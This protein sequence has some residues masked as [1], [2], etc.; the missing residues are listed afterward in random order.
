[1]RLAVLA[2]TS[3]LLIPAAT[4][5][6]ANFNS[7]SPIAMS[8]VIQGPATPYP[9]AISVAGVSEIADVDVTLHQFSHAS[10]KAVDVLLVSPEGRSV[11]LMSDS[12]GGG[13]GSPG[14]AAVS[15][16]EL[17]FDDQAPTTIPIGAALTSGSYQPFDND[18]AGCGVPQ[19]ND[20]YPE[21]ADDPPNGTTLADFN[22]TNPQGDWLLFVNDSQDGAP[23]SIAGWTLNVKTSSNFS[24]GKLKKNKHKGTAKLSVDVPGP[25]TVAVS[26]KG[27]KAARP[28]SG[29]RITAAKAVTEAGTV[30]L[31]IKAKGKKKRKLKSTG[32]VKLKVNVTYTP[33][34]GAP[35]T[36]PKKIKLVDNG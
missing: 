26:G 30:T 16:L 13:S 27:V 4:A 36:E 2:A 33:A 14:C 31:P 3:A 8:G 15:N 35:N 9:S 28:R 18:S 22:G 20:N 7:T 29:E 19:T 24:F 17:N 11:V 25:G 6:A 1:M 23:G 10:P 5:D 21:P 12:P 34:G 32:R